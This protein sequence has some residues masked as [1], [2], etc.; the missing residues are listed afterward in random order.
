[1]KRGFIVLGVCAL[2]F[3]AYFTSS[4]WA[5]HHTTLTFY[6]ALRSDRTVTVELRWRDVHGQIQH[7]QL[8][9]GDG[10]DVTGERRPDLVIVR[11]GTLD[12]PELIKPSATIWTARAPRWA[13]IDETTQQFEG[14]PPPVA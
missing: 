11:V 10:V 6:D 12:D 8:V 7:R 14:Q 5:I 9:Q 13:C 4:K 2:A 1:M 3:G